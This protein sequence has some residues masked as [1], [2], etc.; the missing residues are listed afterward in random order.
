MATRLKSRNSEVYALEQ[1]GYFIGKKIGQ[2]IINNT[3]N[4][5]HI[6]IKN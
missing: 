3:L 2:V 4:F 6:Y 5:I 1:R